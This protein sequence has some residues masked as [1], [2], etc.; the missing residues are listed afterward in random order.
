MGKAVTVREVK[1]KLNSIVKDRKFRVHK[2]VWGDIVIVLGSKGLPKGL[3]K[4]LKQYYELE[5]VD[6]VGPHRLVIT[7]RKARR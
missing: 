5:E 1:A 6:V 7:G 2:N 3:K 4:Y